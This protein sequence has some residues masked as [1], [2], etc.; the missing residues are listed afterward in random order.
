VVLSRDL[1]SIPP[2]EIHTVRAEV[3]VLGGKVVFRR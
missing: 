3:T 1:F 2:I